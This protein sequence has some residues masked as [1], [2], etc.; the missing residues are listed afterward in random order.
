MLLS[1]N[2]ELLNTVPL[3]EKIGYEF[4]DGWTDLIYTLGKNISMYCK[5]HQIP[6]PQPRQIKE[7]FGTLRFYYIDDTN[8]ENI[9]AMVREAEEKSAEICEFCGD[10]GQVMCDGG[11]WKTVCPE[12]T[13]EGS[14]TPEEF[15]VIQESRGRAMRKCDVCSTKGS[16][17]YYDPSTTMH[18][19]RCENHVEDYFITDKD[20]WQQKEKE[21]EDASK[22]K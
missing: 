1:E 15:K 6:L 18:T 20:Y 9:R 13:P 4:R 17:G 14:M 7:K 21:F 19:N 2:R 3:Y 11:H 12:H 22:N 5:V 10:K 8:D 16:D